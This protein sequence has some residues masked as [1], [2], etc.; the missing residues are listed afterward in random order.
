[1]SEADIRAFLTRLGERFRQPAMLYLLG[2]SALPDFL[3]A[4]VPA[5]AHTAPQRGRFAFLIATR[6]GMA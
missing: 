6:E 4:D 5:F 2:G 3:C 1:L